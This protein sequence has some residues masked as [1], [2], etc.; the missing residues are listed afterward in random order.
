MGEETKTVQH[1][2]RSQACLVLWELASAGYF[3]GLGA[4]QMP[5]L[6]QLN[7]AWQSALLR[8][9]LVWFG[10]CSCSSLGICSWLLWGRV[11]T[12]TCMAKLTLVIS[13]GV[14]SQ[15]VKLKVPS[16]VCV[17]FSSALFYA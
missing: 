15:A 14:V 1:Q 10:C 5:A 6:R 9:S 8:H 16:A 12:N 2:R 4:W 7:S 17:I 3:L 11:G 13:Q